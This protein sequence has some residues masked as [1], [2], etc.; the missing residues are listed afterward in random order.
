MLFFQSVA[1][2][3]LD[4]SMLELAQIYRIKK[5]NLILKPPDFGA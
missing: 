4:G 2:D 1:V 3:T 5:I